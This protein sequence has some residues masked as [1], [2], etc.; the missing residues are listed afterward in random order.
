MIK[1][2]TRRLIGVI[3]TILILLF[4]VVSMV[5]LIPGDIVD[6][7]LEERPAQGA[8]DQREKLERELG[9]D[10][11]LVVRYLLYV[12]GI[13]R[14][15]LG[16]SLWTGKTVTSSI[17][18]RAAPTIE[19]GVLAIVLGSIVGVLIGTISAVRQD[20][21]IDYL[22][23]STAILS[24]SVPNFAIAT[25]IIVFPAIW[26]GI[27]PSLRY[28]S[29]TEAPI[30]HLKI[31]I[32]P[33]IVLG[34]SLS[35]SVMRLMRTTILNEL[36]QDYVRT[37]ESKGL[38]YRT[39]VMKHVLKNALIPVVTL[40]GLQVAFLI[41]GSVITESVFAIP[42]VGRLLL[43]SIQSRDYPVLQGVVVVVGF[44][45]I[46]TNLVIDLSYAWLDPRIRYS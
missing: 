18:E 21:V 26:W 42:G 35:A 30:D 45:I 32:A 28:V 6:L 16:D 46:I 24:L 33:A 9:L 2:I 36:R 22:L 44:F 38:R 8:D 12:G 7:I 14:G 27:S 41:G 13:F 37:A 39:V 15:D 20:G 40:L 10:K 43:G 29:F 23:R 1:Y 34:L 31:L 5:D 19:V 17:A 11:P 3:P 4:L 25:G